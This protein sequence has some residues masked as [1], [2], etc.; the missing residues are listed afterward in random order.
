MKG[1]TY[2]KLTIFLG[3]EKQCPTVGS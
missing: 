3:K 2:H 1:T